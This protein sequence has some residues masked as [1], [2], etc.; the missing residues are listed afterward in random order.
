MGRTRILPA[1]STLIGTMGAIIPTKGSIYFLYNLI[2]NIDFS[3]S[4]IGT[5]IPH[6]YFHN[7]GN[8]D[9]NIT[10]KE[11]QS[12]IGKL[13]QNID[14]LITLHQRKCKLFNSSL[15]AASLLDQY[16]YFQVHE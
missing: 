15:K 7:Y 4:I 13:F 12:I 5:T 8:G 2:S 10:S 3:K 11:E 1:N 6:I 16:L 14:S 9:I